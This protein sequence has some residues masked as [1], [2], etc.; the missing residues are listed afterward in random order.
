MENDQKEENCKG[1]KISRLY[2]LKYNGSSMRL[3]W[4]TNFPN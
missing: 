3:E 1:M 2:I 4:Q